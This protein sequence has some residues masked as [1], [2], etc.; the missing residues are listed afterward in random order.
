MKPGMPST[1]C[2]N[3]ALAEDWTEVTRIILDLAR[4]CCRKG[5]AAPIRQNVSGCRSNIWP[6]LCSLQEGAA[7]SLMQEPRKITAHN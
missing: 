7:A 5:A 2:C 6:P 4:I 1:T 3:L